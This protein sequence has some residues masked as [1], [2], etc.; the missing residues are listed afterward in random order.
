M[1]NLAD[2]AAD[3]IPVFRAVPKLR[4]AHATT[5]PSG[6]Y[7]ACVLEPQWASDWSR[8]LKW[9]IDDAINPYH[10][11]D[12]C[13]YRDHRADVW[14]RRRWWTD[15]RFLRGEERAYG[16]LD[17]AWEF[18]DIRNCFDSID[19]HSLFTQIR[20]LDPALPSAVE[21]HF[22]RINYIRRPGLPTGS[23]VSNGLANA[24]LLRVDK[25]FRGH[26]IR[27]GDNYAV[28]PGKLPELRNRLRDLG[29]HTTLRSTFTN[30]SSRSPSAGCPTPPPAAKG[31]AKG[32]AQ[33]GRYE[34]QDITTTTSTST[35]RRAHT[36]KLHSYSLTH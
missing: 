18:C 1:V 3:V 5:L 36:P 12:W 24:F 7:L 32:S 20:R 23:A 21:A 16:W 17:P 25:D 28:A 15:R 6:R 10:C 14:W 35:S 33:G 8:Q 2:P 11:L 30:R 4:F 22:E 29:L 26:A 9:R 27:Y 13:W 31:P 34:H 19:L